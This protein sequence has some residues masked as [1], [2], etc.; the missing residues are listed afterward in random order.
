MR[1]LRRLFLLVLVLTFIG[2]IGTG[3]W[4]GSLRAAPQIRTTDT[5]D[6]RINDW[7]LAFPDL[8][9]SQVRRLREI[10]ARYDA[11]VDQ[12]RREVSAEQFQRIDSLLE[13]SRGEVRLVLEPEQRAR[14]D[15]L[16]KPD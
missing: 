6:R 11:Q 7:K 14:Y 5:L 12:I 4:I 13:Q 2:G 1:E 16:V 9:A 3:A 10:L 15:A 8:T